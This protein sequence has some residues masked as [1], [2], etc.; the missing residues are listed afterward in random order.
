MDCSSIGVG[1]GTNRLVPKFKTRGKIIKLTYLRLFN[2]D[3]V[4]K[5]ECLSLQK[6]IIYLLFSLY[7]SRTKAIVLEPIYAAIN[8]QAKRWTGPVFEW[9]D[10]GIGKEI[11]LS[12]VSY[13]SW[14]QTVSET[15]TAHRTTGE[16]ILSVYYITVYFMDIWIWY[17]I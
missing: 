14:T 10:G 13:A 7:C 4:S 5:L 11:R 2:F 3:N 12:K 8:P 9:S 6:F 16:R 17:K 15:L 1:R